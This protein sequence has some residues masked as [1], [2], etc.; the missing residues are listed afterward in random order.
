MGPLRWGGRTRTLNNGART[1]RVANYT[2]PQEGSPLRGRRILPAPT[3]QPVLGGAQ[4]VEAL[5]PP[6]Q[7]PRVPHRGPDGRAR[8][9]DARRRLEHLELDAERVGRGRVRGPD[10]LTFERLDLLH[11]VERR[12]EEAGCILPCHDLLPRRFVV[13][14]E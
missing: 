1:R 14:G 2:T 6:E 3:W 13:A 7:G 9:G 11:D 12:A 10:R 4:A 8:E 5:G